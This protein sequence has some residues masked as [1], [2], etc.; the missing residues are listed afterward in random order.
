[1]IVEGKPSEDTNINEDC[2]DAF[3]FSRDKRAL[4]HG[5]LVSFAEMK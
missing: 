5:W 1:M 2:A 4:L 3:Y